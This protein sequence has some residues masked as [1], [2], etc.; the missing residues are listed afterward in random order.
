MPFYVIIIKKITYWTLVLKKENYTM[1]FDMKNILKFFRKETVVPEANETQTNI[2]AEEIKEEATYSP[3]QISN[4]LT[5]IMNFPTAEAKYDLDDWKFKLANSEDFT[6]YAN[7]V[8]KTFTPLM[9]VSLFR[10]S[11]SMEQ[12]CWMGGQLV[13]TLIDDPENLTNLFVQKQRLSN[14][15]STRA[16]LTSDYRKEWWKITAIDEDTKTMQVCFTLAFPIN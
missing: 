2:E 5:E 7:Q 12:E 15:S 3:M 14:G 6:P 11:G 13:L 1:Q 10:G 4:S 9:C 16:H 8:R